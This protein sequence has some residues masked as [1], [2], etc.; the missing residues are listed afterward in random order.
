MGMVK[1]DLKGIATDWGA[2]PGEN[3][4]CCIVEGSPLDVVKMTRQYM[5]YVG[6][7]VHP[8]APV[9]DLDELLIHMAG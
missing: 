7:R 9:C 1:Q 4:V 8:F 2:F 5:P 3:R 6:F